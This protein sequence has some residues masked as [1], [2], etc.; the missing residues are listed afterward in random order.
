[1]QVQLRAVR[2]DERRPSDLQQ[3]SRTCEEYYVSEPLR[4]EC[5]QF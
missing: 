2:D 1:M 3:L 5:S 4:D